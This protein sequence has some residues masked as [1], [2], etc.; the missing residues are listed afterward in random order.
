MSRF[1]MTRQL[2][3][4]ASRQDD[5]MVKTTFGL[6]RISLGFFCMGRHVIIFEQSAKRVRKGQGQHRCVKD[7]TTN[8][9]IT[10]VENQLE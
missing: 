5:E 6:I 9:T 10:S 7:Y 4:I 1:G 2:A 8:V 3:D